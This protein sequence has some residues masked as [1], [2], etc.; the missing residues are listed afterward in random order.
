MRREGRRATGVLAEPGVAVRGDVYQLFNET[1]QILAAPETFATKELA[2]V[3]ADK[4]RKRFASQGFYL[5]VEG[6]RIPPESVKLVVVPAD[7]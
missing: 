4:L 2:Q 5:T 1:D 6:K 3:C 7:A